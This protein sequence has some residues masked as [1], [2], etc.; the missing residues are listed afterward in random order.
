MVKYSDVLKAYYNQQKNILNV[1]NNNDKNSFEETL[2][3]ND[4]QIK[5]LESENSELNT[6]LANFAKVNDSIEI[7]Y[8]KLNFS[9]NHLKSENMTLVSKISACVQKA[10]KIMNRME[11][12]F[13]NLIK[14]VMI[15]IKII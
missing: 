10:E 3:S 14:I 1:I 9:H 8:K 12:C 4:E 15:T 6:N 7:K 13:K 2:K 11:F 5:K